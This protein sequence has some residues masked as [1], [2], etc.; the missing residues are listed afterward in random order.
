[1]KAI[2]NTLFIFIIVLFMKNSTAF[3]QQKVSPALNHIA[4]SVYDLNESTK[5]YRDVIG[6]EII[7]EPFK[8][9]KHT[10]FSLGNLGQLHVIAGAE[11]EVKHLRSSHICFSV[12]SIEDYIKNLEHN[13]IEYSNWSGD[14]NAVT[15]RPD[16]IKQIYFQDPDG[17]WIEVNNDHK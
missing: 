5:F 1:M 16:G 12:T 15:L 14:R 6:L 2:F 3:A 9:G 17:Y 4:I 13:K 11:K 8:D 10:W 7:P